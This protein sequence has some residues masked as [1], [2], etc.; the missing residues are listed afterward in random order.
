MHL[1]DTNKLRRVEE[2]VSRYIQEKFSF[3]IFAVETKEER[4]M[5]EKKIISTILKCKECKPSSTWLG[6]FSPL[7]KIRESGLWN[8]QGLNSE[9]MTLVEFE[10]LKRK[11]DSF[12]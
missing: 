12:Y 7:Q 6:S 9:E 2:E 3:V 8:V 5:W 10:K 4:L 1:L 11:V